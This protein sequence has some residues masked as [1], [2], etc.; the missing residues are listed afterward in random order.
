MSTLTR[1]RFGSLTL[2]LL[3]TASLAA[4][5]GTT[6]NSSESASGGSGLNSV[7]L[8]IANI[9]WKEDAALLKAAGLSD[10]PYTVNI[11][12]FDGGNNSIQAIGSGNMDVTRVSVIP[13]VFASQSNGGKSFSIPAVLNDGITGAGQGIIVPPGSAIKTVAGLRGKKVG[14]V[15][16]TTAQ[17]FLYRIL[18]QNNLAW[19]DI[20]P[21][22]LSPADGATAVMKGDIDAFAGFGGG[23]NTAVAKGATYVADGQKV[24]PPYYPYVTSKKLLSDANRRA[25]LFDYL[26]RISAG[27]AW[28]AK[29]P[30]EWGK[31]SGPATGATPQIQTELIKKGLAQISTK[32]IAPNDS[33]AASTQDV[34]DVFKRV[35]LLSATVDA[36]SLYDE[37]YASEL[38]AAV[39]KYASGASSSSTPK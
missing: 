31:I 12:V 25:A 7:T 4:C 10:T 5:G 2:G 33:V 27:Y 32:V 8:N 3:T 1:R 22:K 19:S 37:Q 30:A 29:N 36:K 17:Y 24:L 38:D 23:V 28:A 13:P 34:A 9:Q 6:K 18:V 16:G 15:E 11:Q 39:A 26:G 21:V 35:G 20:I 14:Y